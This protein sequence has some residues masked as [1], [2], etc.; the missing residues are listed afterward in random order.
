MS[1]IQRLHLKLH[2]ESPTFNWVLEPFSKP[3][4]ILDPET[5]LYFIR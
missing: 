4:V 3:G 5:V 2:S 1:R